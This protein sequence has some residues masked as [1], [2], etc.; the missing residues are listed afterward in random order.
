MAPA[1]I[2][3]VL[4]HENDADTSNQELYKLSLAAVPLRV[5]VT[6]PRDFE[7]TGDLLE[8]YV[9]LVD[10][11]PVPWM[12]TLMVILGVPR[13][14]SSKAVW[15]AYVYRNDEASFDFMEPGL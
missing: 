2:L 5:L 6:Y 12:G 4:E 13:R 14:G 1:N 8:S 15:D 11:S 9:S 3:V 10:D 7:H